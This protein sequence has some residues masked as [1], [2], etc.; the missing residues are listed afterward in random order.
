MYAFV[1]GVLRWIYERAETAHAENVGG[2][3]TFRIT[4]ASSFI[5]GVGIVSGVSSAVAGLLLK[6]LF[7]LIFGLVIAIG[8]LVAWPNIV[9]ADELGLTSDQF[10]RPQRRIAWQAVS[11]AEFNL[12]NHLT[13]IT[14]SDGTRIYHTGFH[15]DPKLLHKL[16]DTNSPRRVEYI[17]PT[18]SGHRKVIRHRD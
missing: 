18:W 16:I 10:L 15:C 11:S 14:A 1:N 17:E 5:L 3:T 9:S 8:L 4:V 6:D 13:K 2:Q 12:A 7:W